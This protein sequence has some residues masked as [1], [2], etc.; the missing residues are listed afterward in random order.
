MLESLRRIHLEHGVITPALVAADPGL[1]SF[2]VVTRHFG[3]ITG[4]LYRLYA[5]VQERARQGVI[6]KIKEYEGKVE[7]HQ[8]FLV[9]NDR[10]TVL[11]QPAVPV[12][13]FESP[14]WLFRP[15]QRPVVDITVGVPL[16]DHE[17]GVILGYLVMPRLMM[18]TG[19]LRLSGS[20]AG[21]IDLHGYHGLEFLKEY[22]A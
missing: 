9:I 12:L 13:G 16:A 20:N 6:A 5:D 19:W 2:G 10:V 18:P 17:E 1:P 22:V 14:S 21:L 11:I 4:A 15:D 7:L 3:G 8:D